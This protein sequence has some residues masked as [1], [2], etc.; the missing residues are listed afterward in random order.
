MSAK[1]LGGWQLTYAGVAPVTRQSG[2]KSAVL[3]RY[4]CNLRLRNAIYHWAGALIGLCTTRADAT[5]SVLSR[6]GFCHKDCREAEGLV[7]LH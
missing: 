3:M 2:K 5:I 6:G 7:E 4:G 1:L